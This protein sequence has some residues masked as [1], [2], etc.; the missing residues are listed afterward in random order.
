MIGS[1]RILF[2]PILF[3]LFY[4]DYF[5]NPAPAQHQP[6][7]AGQLG[8]GPGQSDGVDGEGVGDVPV[9]PQHGDVIVEMWC[10]PKTFVDW[11][12]GDPPS[13]LVRLALVDVVA[14][15]SD[16][17]RPSLG[18]GELSEAVAGGE[19]VTGTDEAATT[20]V[21]AAQVEAGHVRVGAFPHHGS[22][23]WEGL[24]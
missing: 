15:Q 11:D 10:G 18:G 16:Q 6:S 9:Q 24:K 4:L 17:Q 7:L 8:H 1:F 3:N 14:T 19:D 20:E 12:L 22:V 5:P 13:D 23:D 21:F 2:F